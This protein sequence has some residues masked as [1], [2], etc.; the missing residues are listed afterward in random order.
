MTRHTNSGTPIRQRR[1]FTLI[2][3]SVIM[4]ALAL[5]L[6]LTSLITWGAM[7]LERTAAGGLQSLTA[8]QAF[9]DQFRTD[10]GAAADAPERW[11]EDTAGPTCLILHRGEKRYVIYRWSEERL[12][13]SEL[14]GETARSIP[15]SLGANPTRVQ[16]SRTGQDGRLLVARLFTVHPDGRED[17]SAEIMA[18]LGGELK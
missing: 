18:A 14:D 11:Q 5:A 1:G 12:E 10:V 4:M 13:R 15:V 6:A 7:R 2:E 3:M 9:I 16:F 17:Q 8:R